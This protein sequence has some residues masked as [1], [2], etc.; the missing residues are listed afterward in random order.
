VVR[1]AQ[2]RIA[3]SAFGVAIGIDTS[4][5]ALLSSVRP[6]LPP[7]STPVSWD[8]A[9]AKFSVT[10]TGAGT[11]CISQDERSLLAAV[12]L[13]TAIDALDVH[14]RMFIATHAPE[15]VFVH[16]GAVTHRGRG[17]LLPGASFAGKTELVASLVRIGATYYSDE[18]AVLDRDGLVH[19]YP[20]PLSIRT[21]GKRDSLDV[22]V[23]ELGGEPGM[24]PAPIGILA[25]THFDPTS[26][27]RP[28]SRSPAAGAMILLAHSAL[29]RRDP[30]RA[31]RSVHRAVQHA[32][33]LEGPRGE[34]EPTAKALLTALE[35][36][37]GPVSEV[38]KPSPDP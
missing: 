34:A 37:T 17:L 18:Y 16:A 22:D 20:R 13:A 7:A 11:F 15:H 33:V 14:I 5:D 25:A 10:R 24:G 29:A 19:P 21:R 30:M 9:L 6:I 28:E 2:H 38:P 27:W 31:L 3:L 36:S 1:V 12:E 32:Q 23:R 26:T 35:A 4:D 8:E